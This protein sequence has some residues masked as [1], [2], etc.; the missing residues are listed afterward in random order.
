VALRPR[1]SLGWLL[2]RR[3]TPGPLPLERELGQGGV[4]TI[5]LARDIKHDRLVALKVLHPEL[6]TSLGPE[7]CCSFAVVSPGM[8][9][10]TTGGK[11]APMLGKWPFPNKLSGK[12]AP[13]GGLWIR[14][15]LVRVQEGQ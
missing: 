8:S 14:R 15:V 3:P 7:H 13:A 9:G 11:R 2:S 1:L 10:Q 6:A 5:Q 12:V 4:A